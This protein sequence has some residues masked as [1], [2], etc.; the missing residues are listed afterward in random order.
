MN[1][2]Q[3][4]A[5]L[6]VITFLFVLVLVVY[7]II[8]MG[9]RHRLPELIFVLIWVPIFILVMIVGLFFICRK[10][11]PTEPDFDERDRLI[12]H[13][14]VLAAFVSVWV[15]LAAESIIP[16][17][18]V[19]SDGSLPVWLLPIMNGCLF[20]I[21]WLV[22]SIAVLVQYGFRGKGEKS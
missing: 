3:K 13:R 5:W 4:G 6:N 12:E 18:I 1:K 15:T 17:F 11:S 9:I 16:K 22:Y 21:V 7:F 10:Q 19:G 8:Q 20:I 2:T 14:A